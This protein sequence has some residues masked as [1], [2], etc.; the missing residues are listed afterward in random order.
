MVATATSF[1]QLKL[2]P[3]TQAALT[4]WGIDTPTPIQSGAIPALLAGRD[5]VGQARTGS[6]KTLAFAI[7]IV[8]RCDASKP[9]IQA[10]ILVPTRELTGQVAGVVEPLAAARRLGLSLLYGGRALG[11]ERQ[12]LHNGRQIV[13]G[14]PGRTLDHLRQGNLSLRQL[15]MCVLDEGDEMLDKGFAPAVEQILAYAPAQRQTALLSATLPEWVVTTGA[16][17]LRNPALFRVDRETQPPPEIEHLIYELE[18]DAK[19]AALRTLLDRRGE[20]Q[21][22]VFGRTKHGINKLARQLSGQRYP[23]AAL[24]GNLSQPAR[25]RVMAG[26][27]SDATPILL[28]EAS[29]LRQRRVIGAALTDRG[30]LLERAQ[31]RPTASWVQPS[32]RGQ[33]WRRRHRPTR[34]GRR[35]PTA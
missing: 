1:V 33:W 25:H 6:G 28:A 16:R 32:E 8:E 9:G 3:A 30:A 7:P 22:L 27:R 11:P 20:G 35:S 29:G 19:L 13:V 4:K 15:R 17:Y 5:I 14:T 2:H 34:S 12:A 24:Q 31:S 21:L 23:V 18:P 10:L 26:F